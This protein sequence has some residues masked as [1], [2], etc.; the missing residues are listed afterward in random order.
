MNS[1]HVVHVPSPH[2]FKSR[3]K[4]QVACYSCISLM[5]DSTSRQLYEEDSN[6]IINIT[7]DLYKTLGKAGVLVPKD[8]TKC[9]ETYSTNIPNYYRMN[10]VFCPNTIAEPGACVKLK[11]HHNG[12]QYIY[13]SCWGNMWIDKRPYARQMSERCY[14]DEVVQNFVA[15]TDNKICFCEDDLCNSSHSVVLDGIYLVLAIIAKFMH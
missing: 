9:T 13:R 12:D 6:I 11:G 4:G 3:L 14:I 2:V 15:T 5:H 1:G 7:A 10:L 8:V